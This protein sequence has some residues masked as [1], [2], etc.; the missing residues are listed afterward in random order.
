MNEGAC[1]WVAT[2]LTGEAAVLL[3]ETGIAEII[4]VIFLR[5]ILTGRKE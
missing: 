2:E 1:N 4:E 3:S 5:F